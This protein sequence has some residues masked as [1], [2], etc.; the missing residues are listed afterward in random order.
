MNSKSFY[1]S[2]ALSQDRE[3]H[4][5]R[6]GRRHAAI[7]GCARVGRGGP[8][9]AGWRC[10][11]CRGRQKAG[12]NFSRH[13]R[14]YRYFPSKRWLWRALMRRARD[15]G[16]SRRCGARRLLLGGPVPFGGLLPASAPFAVAERWR[17]A[18][19]GFRAP[20][21]ETDRT[22][23]KMFSAF[24]SRP[25]GSLSSKKIRGGRSASFLT[26]RWPAG[27]FAEPG[28][29]HSGL[30][31]PWWMGCRSSKGVLEWNSLAAGC[32]WMARPER[33]PRR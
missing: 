6:I 24:D 5:P 12:G 13:G 14:F 8:P 10:A 16:K 32:G 25:G 4:P 27:I 18:G 1:P 22:G 15:R 31:G 11:D 9:K 30:S 21:A 19:L 7:R 28:C 33:W 2:S 17:T 20:W 26:G 3:C 29:C 23:T